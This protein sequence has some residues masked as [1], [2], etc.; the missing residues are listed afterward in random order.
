MI[1]V[2][3]KISFYGYKYISIKN[4]NKMLIQS[5]STK[6]QDYRFKN[7]SLIVNI[8]MPKQGQPSCTVRGRKGSAFP[9]AT[10]SPGDKK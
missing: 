1:Q 2:V 6:E 9:C 10:G 4:N 3:V 5:T 7:D 8:S